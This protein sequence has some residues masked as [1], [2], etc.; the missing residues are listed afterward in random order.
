MD[1]AN[2]IDLLTKID[3]THLNHEAPSSL[4]HTDRVKHGELTIKIN[5]KRLDRVILIMVISRKNK[6]N[7]HA[8]IGYERGQSKS[9]LRIVFLYQV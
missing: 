7:R 1:W 5:N 9:K 6:I 3:L 2:A 8:V 4:R